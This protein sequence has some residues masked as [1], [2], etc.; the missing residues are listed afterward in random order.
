MYSLPGG[1]DVYENVFFKRPRKINV[2]IVAAVVAVGF[3]C[4]EA[5]LST[6]SSDSMLD[7]EYYSI[8]G[9]DSGIFSV[10][11]YE[12]SLLDDLPW[13]ADFYESAENIKS[14]E[15]IYPLIAG[16]TNLFSAKDYETINKI[17][18][19][20]PLDKLSPTVMVALM[21]TT[22]PARNKLGNWKGAVQSVSDSLKSRGLNS[23]RI[24]R[25]L[26]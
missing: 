2:S 26:E 16:I 7:S 19:E 13:L 15:M 8:D 1:S 4:F 3:V 11:N 17:L 20:V 25:G 6:E 23:A 10:T 9:P 5:P 12:S 21:R 22:F 18:I 14:A 24:L